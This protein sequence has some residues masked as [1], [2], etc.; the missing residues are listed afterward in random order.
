MS[1]KSSK[2]AEKAKAEKKAKQQGKDTGIK[3]VFRLQIKTTTRK[4]S[5]N[6]RCETKIQNAS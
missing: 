2:F 3:D 5:K 6:G 4:N 1:N